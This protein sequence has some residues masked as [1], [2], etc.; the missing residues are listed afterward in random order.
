VHQIH[1]SQIVLQLGRIRTFSGTTDFS[2]WSEGWLTPHAL[3]REAL[4][5]MVILG[6]AGTRQRGNIMGLHAMISQTTA[7][8]VSKYGAPSKT[9]T[10]RVWTETNW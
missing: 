5:K 4:L 1:M 6:H 2:P 3:V 8:P 9:T 10:C 7:H